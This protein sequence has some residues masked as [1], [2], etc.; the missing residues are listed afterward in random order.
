[1]QK[2]LKLYGIYVIILLSGQ[3]LPEELGKYI[4]LTKANTSQ[5]APNSI[6]G[7]SSLKRL[8]HYSLVLWL[9]GFFWLLLLSLPALF[10]LL[11]GF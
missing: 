8:Y 3:G 7:S 4:W 11:F 5:E 10:A 9:L 1:M 6:N 2:N